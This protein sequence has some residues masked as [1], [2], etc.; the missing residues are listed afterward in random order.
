MNR[1]KDCFSEFIFA[2]IQKLKE[3]KNKK[4]LLNFIKGFNKYLFHKMEDP[5]LLANF[6]VVNV[7]YLKTKYT[8]TLCFNDN[9]TG[10]V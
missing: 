2:L 5:L 1:W 3:S 7:T 9:T 4:I 8:H 6:L 10:H